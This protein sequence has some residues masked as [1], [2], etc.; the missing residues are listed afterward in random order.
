SQARYG[1]LLRLEGRAPLVSNR[2]ALA[3]EPRTQSSNRG[4]HKNQ[5]DCRPHS[6][7]GQPHHAYLMNLYAA[8]GAR[9]RRYTPSPSR[10]PAALVFPST[11]VIVP[12]AWTCSTNPIC[13]EPSEFT[14]AN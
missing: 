3:L 1:V 12:V 7:A 11:V 13:P 8:V 4:N 9:V 2:S 14:H 6:D 5:G 10:E